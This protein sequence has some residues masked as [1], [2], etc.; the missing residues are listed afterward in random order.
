VLVRSYR[1]RLSGTTAVSPDAAPGAK[2][3]DEIG[4]LEAP[5]Y[6]VAGQSSGQDRS[7]PMASG[8]L[9]PDRPAAGVVEL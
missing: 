4:R 7:A 6:D 5:T 9:G 8:A 2:Q 3:M 1:R